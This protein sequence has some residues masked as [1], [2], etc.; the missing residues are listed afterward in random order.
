MAIN[1]IQV[2]INDTAWPKKNRRKFLEPR[3]RTINRK[4]WVGLAMA[5]FRCFAGSCLSH[6]WLHYYFFR[7]ALGA[8]R[9]AKPGHAVKAHP[10]YSEHAVKRLD[11]RCGRV[12]AAMIHCS[13]TLTACDPKRRFDWA[14]RSI[15]NA[16]GNLF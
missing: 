4:P 5:E 6:G 12:T 15:S 13:V 9:E 7:T 3:A 11:S 16:L 10:A 2:P 8:I 1:C 14:A